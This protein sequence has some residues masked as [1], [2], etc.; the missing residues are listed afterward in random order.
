MTGNQYPSLNK[1]PPTSIVQ[2]F[3]PVFVP[4]VQNNQVGNDIY[5]DYVQN[6][7]NLTLQQQP[8]SNIQKDELNADLIKQQQ[9]HQVIRSDSQQE[10][11]QSSIINSNVQ[12]QQQ[13]QLDPAARSGNM[14]QTSNYFGGHVDPSTIPPGSEFLFG[15]P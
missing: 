8:Q 14:F 12:Q 3:S 11:G 2:S 7:Y 15:R 13:S 5:Y 6:P 9:Q 10:Q 1:V 4:H